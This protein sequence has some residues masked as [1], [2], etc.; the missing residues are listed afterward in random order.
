MLHSQGHKAWILLLSVKFPILKS[1]NFLIWARSL[2]CLFAAVSFSVTYGWW[3]SS[4]FV[5][6]GGGQEIQSLSLQPNKPLLSSRLHTAVPEKL[7]R[8]GWLTHRRRFTWQR[9]EKIYTRQYQWMWYGYFF[10]PVFLCACYRCN[11]YRLQQIKGIGNEVTIN[12]YLRL[13]LWLSVGWQTRKLSLCLQLMGSW[14]TI[15]LA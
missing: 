13:K 11:Y 5:Q 1:V 9:W 12:R 2:F 3:F 8:S 6:E 15:W 7:L 4:S 10:V 14:A